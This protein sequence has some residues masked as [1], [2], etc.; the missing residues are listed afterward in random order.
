M[1]TIMKKLTKLQEKVYERLNSGDTISIYKTGTF[2]G[3]DDYYRWDSDLSVVPLKTVQSMRRKG[4]EIITNLVEGVIVKY[5][6]YNDP[7]KIIVKG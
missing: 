7:K 5:D 3:Y 4:V 6:P 1:F 2:G